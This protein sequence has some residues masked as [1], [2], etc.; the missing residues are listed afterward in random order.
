VKLSALVLDHQEKI[1]QQDSPHPVVAFFDMDRTLIQGFS[2]LAL[3]FEA[4]LS[5]QPG[6]RRIA[7]EMLVNIDRRDGSRHYT[8]LYRSL[9]ASLA[10]TPEVDLE[11]L[12]ERAFSR[13]LGSSI[14]TEARQ[15]VRYHR[16]LGHKLVIVSAATRY[17]VEPVAR[18]LGIDD[19][20]CTQVKV[21]SG[22][23]TGELLGTLCYGEGK[24]T[25]ARRMARLHGA[26][27]TDSWFYSD[28][29]D[30][31]PLL[32]KVGN[33]VATNPS[34]SLEQQALARQWP[35]LNFCSRGKPNL[36]SLVRT[37][38]TASTLASTAAAGAASWLVTG[39]PKRAR[40]QMSSFLGG[41]GS[42]FAG[43]EFEI[44]GTEH[45]E[46]VRPAIFT[47]NHQ[48]YLDSVI[49]AQLLRHDFVG[50]CKREL[51]DH[52]LL[53]PLLKAHG[54]IFVDRDA[55]DQSLCLEQA[56]TAL[57][58]GKSLAIAPEGTRS[59]TGELLDFKQGAF[60]LARKMAVPIVPVVLHNVADALPKG[61]WLLRPATIQVTVLPPLAAGDLGSLR[62]AS[63][64]L[65][66]RYQAALDEDWLRSTR[67]TN[68]PMRALDS[69]VSTLERSTSSR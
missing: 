63:K 33:P 18:A 21:R 29:S 59:A 9:L 51:A 69:G 25:A 52:R 57:L 65:R 6:M 46:A 38:L 13:S 26:S 49:M 27:L 30:D 32:K 48:S 19:I 55:A 1:L 53:G 42:A 45:L 5:R 39:S 60:Y 8:R 37:V 3:A 68:L 4:I 24:V 34:P 44:D 12:G 11:R 40:N 56:R 35:I 20:C 16:E 58:E 28:S 62:D 2:A 14:F 67:S 43:L 50:F 47:F 64:V 7:Q 10:G 22:E 17:Q 54:T 61:R 23:L 41:L 15:L 66:E 36:E 31:M